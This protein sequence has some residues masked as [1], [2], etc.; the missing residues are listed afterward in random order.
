MSPKTSSIFHASRINEYFFSRFWLLTFTGDKY[1]IHCLWENCANSTSER[2]R[3]WTMI[4]NFFVI[5]NFRIRVVTYLWEREVLQ[6]VP[7]GR[8]GNTVFV[9]FL[10]DTKSNLSDSWRINWIGFV[11]VS[12]SLSNALSGVRQN[13]V[14]VFVASY[15][16]VMPQ[17]QMWINKYTIL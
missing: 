2:S 14:S 5:K 7:V 16:K 13:A 9:N 17:K 11:I 15:L 6:G 1:F 10:V 4:S 8:Q 12:K 3:A